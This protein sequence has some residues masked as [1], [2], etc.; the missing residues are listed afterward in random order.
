MSVALLLTNNL[1]NSK[2]KKVQPSQPSSTLPTH[3]LF[4][5][6]LKVQHHLPPS[7]RSLRHSFD[8]AWNFEQ[9]KKLEMINSIW[10]TNFGEGRS[11]ECLSFTETTVTWREHPPPGRQRK[12]RKTVQKLTTKDTQPKQRRSLSHA[13]ATQQAPSQRRGTSWDPRWLGETQPRVSTGRIWSV[14]DWMR[15][16]RLELELLSRRRKLYFTRI[17]AGFAV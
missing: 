16:L 6:N 3:D 4:W 5:A 13:V 10:L 17:T 15:R 7:L 2:Q 1:D 11:N 8:L 9:I 14:S 12:K